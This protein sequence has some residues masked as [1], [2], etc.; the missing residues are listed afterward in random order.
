MR[1]VAH[2]VDP[3][4][5]R[6]AAGAIGLAIALAA[7]ASAGPALHPSPADWRDVVIYQVLTD[8]FANGDPSND[9]AEGNL[10]PADGARIHGG[11]F[12]GLRQR[13]DYVQSLGA[14]AVWISP[15]VLNTNA[16]YHGYSARDL[17]SIAPHF[18]TLAELRALADDLHARGMY[19]ILD[20]VVNHMGDLIDSGDAGYPEFRYPATYTLR[21][22]DPGKRH[23]G[24]FDDLSKFHAHGGVQNDVD[25][26]RVLG[27]LYSLDDLKTEDPVVQQE[28]IR[29]AAFLIDSTD[30]DGFRLDTAKHVDLGFWQVYGPAVHA[31]AASRGKE[32]FFLFGEA[33]DGSD[34]KV[35]S[36]TGTRGGGPYKLDSMLYFPMYFTA[37]DV[38]RAPEYGVPPAE[39][40]W[41]YSFLDRYDPTSRE[42]LVTFLDNHDVSR[43]VGFATVSGNDEGKL[44]PALGWLLTSRGVPCVYYGT[45][46]M[47]DGG[48][49]PYNRED[50]WDGEWDFGPS[51]GDN[52]DQARPLARGMRRLADARR[53]H[54]A[55]RRGVTAELYAE[56]GDAGLYLFQRTTA[57]DAVLVAINT[58]RSSIV[59]LDQPVPWPEGTALVDA[60]E[61][62]VR[63]T[64]GAGGRLTL[65][66]PAR[67]VG[68]WETAAD[69]AA[70]A[71]A[72]PLR[73]ETIFPGHDQ[74]LA[75][76]HSALCVGFDRP[77]DPVTLPGAFA[78]DPPIVGTWS[79]LGR[80]AVFY[81]SEPWQAATRYRW[82]LSA[83]LEARD[84]G[85]LELP[86]ESTFLTSG[87]STGVTAAAGF[88]VDLVARQD[89]Q[90]PEALLPA[91][92]LGP[93][94]LLLGDS[95]RR[96]LYT[97]SLGGDLGYWLDDGY[98]GRVE[99]LT[100]DAEGGL[101]V[102]GDFLVDRVDARR[103]VTRRLPG[104]ISAASGAMA[105]G[106]GAFGGTLYLGSPYE[107]AVLRFGPFGLLEVFASGIPGAE[108]LAF[109]PGGAW[110]TDLYV[111]DANLGSVFSASN[112][113]GRIV[114]VNPA[115]AVGAHV[116]DPVLLAGASALAFDTHGRFGGDLF[117][118]DILAE[119]ILR[120]T[121]AGGVSVFATGFQNLSG[122]QCLAF[123]PDGA[124]YVADAGS[125]VSFS[126]SGGSEPCAVLR[127]APQ[128]LPA[129]A[130]QAAARLSLAAPVPNP[131]VRGALL[132]FELP[133]AARAA[134]ALYDVSGRRVRALRSAELAAGPHL[135]TWDGR[136]DAGARVAAGLYFAALDVAGERR[137]T[138][139]LVVVR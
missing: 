6:A 124:L 5:R 47:F 30:C 7:A 54:E 101:F 112:G 118:A 120:V 4:P 123:G 133:R 25:P 14:D 24:L 119:R 3:A 76:L 92:W 106:G 82:S 10:A 57:S 102:G 60:L 62:S 21:W 98:W 108:G 36:Y 59:R 45:E 68:V 16:E 89:L 69:G 20:V 70:A 84:G 86:F 42:Q 117:V 127:I 105:W 139:R 2:P 56:P 107:D 135:V 65:R 43:F 132:R 9:A 19:L 26:D 49:D 116:V 38:F 34:D 125:G 85:T 74:R 103:M 35:G 44:W 109:G 8:R 87:V 37:G 111:A 58:A 23:A 126:N 81:P 88:V 51:E 137:L 134:L 122:S 97:L 113:P 93:D 31:H 80:S 79:V 64:V 71:A 61:P 72:A 138:Q 48:G 67:G 94:V 53:R 99:G 75:D 29:A 32:R 17:F 27:E 40:S 63:D 114:R 128:A 73:I 110:G 50:M 104:S 130:A 131:T 83:A 39:L 33:F 90:G 13:L 28:L 77:P 12:A 1:I 55:L 121:P 15:V 46:Q 41:R 91:P 136:D 18:G 66:V 52:F 95:G 22:K 129:D 78:I 11:D 115:G 96:R 100:P